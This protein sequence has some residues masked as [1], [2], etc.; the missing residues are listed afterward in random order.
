[1][2]GVESI[3]D[4]SSDFELGNDDVCDTDSKWS[5]SELMSLGVKMKASIRGKLLPDSDSDSAAEDHLPLSSLRK[6]RNN[7]E[8]HPAEKIQPPNVRESTSS[9]TEINSTPETADNVTGMPHAAVM[10]PTRV[11]DKPLIVPIPDSLSVTPPSAHET[12]STLRSSSTVPIEPGPSSVASDISSE[13][14]NQGAKK[15][16]RKR[17]CQASKWYRQAST[18]KNNKPRM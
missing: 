13:H 15:T 1:M 12:K 14:V 6:K 2:D 9:S 16:R 3:A 11:S 10:V 18:S 17:P 7:Q 8:L 5:D 4:S